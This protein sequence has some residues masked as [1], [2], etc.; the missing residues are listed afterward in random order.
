MITK[1]REFRMNQV[2]LPSHLLWLDPFD[3]SGADFARA[4]A[5][6]A[7]FPPSKIIRTETKKNRKRSP[8]PTT[9]SKT[10]AYTLYKYKAGWKEILLK[11][12][13]PAK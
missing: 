2:I 5:C 13:A 3:L 6:A 7:R 12:T 9:E 8:T 1:Y 10:S 11:I 4:Y